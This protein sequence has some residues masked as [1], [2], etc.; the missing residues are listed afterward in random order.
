MSDAAVHE[1]FG[2]ILAIFGWLFAVVGYF[3]QR[4]I[5]SDREMHQ[6]HFDHAADLELHQTERDRISIRDTL[7]LS[8]DELLRHTQ[9]DDRRFERMDSK[10][11]EI[12]RDIRDILKAVKP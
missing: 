8:A 1:M 10:M 7:R 3:F 6:K 5:A 9:Q 11:D 4:K 12:G 2:V